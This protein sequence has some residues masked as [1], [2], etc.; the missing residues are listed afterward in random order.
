LF[1]SAVLLGVG[2]IPCLG[3]ALVAIVLMIGI[4]AALLTTLGTKEYAL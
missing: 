3:W 2:W 1:F 4:G